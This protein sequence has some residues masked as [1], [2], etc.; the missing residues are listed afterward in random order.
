MVTITVE[1]N[2]TALYL[3]AAVVVSL[4]A[5]ILVMNYRQREH[6]RIIKLI[7][8]AIVDYFRRTG[9]EVSV[10]CYGSLGTQRF[11][12]LVESE[13]IKKFRCSHIIEQSLIQHVFKVTG[14][15][16]EKVYW[17]FPLARQ[18]EEL[19]HEVDRADQDAY[20][21]EGLFQARAPDGYLVDEVPWES[22]NA[23][24]KEKG[25]R[26]TEAKP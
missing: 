26:E 10:S 2:L 25:N 23:A 19:A 8:D 9:I 12:V 20:L 6:N 7:S 24:I 17:R 18:P 15:Q 11:I 5:Y 21:T 16:V 14:K 22:F 3:V 13:P 1:F 4:L